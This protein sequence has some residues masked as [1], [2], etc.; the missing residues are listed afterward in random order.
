M[1]YERGTT[2]LEKG[3]LTLSNLPQ[4]HR[5]YVVKRLNV[6]RPIDGTSQGDWAG[7]TVISWAPLVSSH[8]REALCTINTVF[9]LVIRL[10]LI[11]LH[12]ASYSP[13]RD[14]CVKPIL[15]LSS[16]GRF[17]RVP[18]N[19]LNHPKWNFFNGIILAWSSAM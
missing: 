14:R 3:N 6:L 7:A 8:K 10:A 13:A 2:R 4:L 15:G 9:R 12:S 1:Q 16:H 17:H 11:W 18:G 19:I 5:L